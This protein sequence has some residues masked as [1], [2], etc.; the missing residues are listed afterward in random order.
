MNEKISATKESILK[1]MN[2]V[3]PGTGKSTFKQITEILDFRKIIP[4]I[5]L[6]IISLVFSGIY[7][8][9]TWEA[10]WAIMKDHWM[11]FTVAWICVGLA[12]IVI[13]RG[14]FKD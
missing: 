9:R 12:N 2:E 14:F 11:P 5:V 8:V 10:H 4:I 6:L 7:I 13:R 1:K 3:M